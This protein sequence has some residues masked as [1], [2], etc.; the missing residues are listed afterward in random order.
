MPTG[1]PSSTATAHRAAEHSRRDP[2]DQP[3]AYRVSIAIALLV[4]LLVCDAR[5]QD[6]DESKT[7]DRTRVRELIGQLGSNTRAARRQAE[8]ALVSLGPAVLPFLPAPELL[9]TVSVK[10][11]VRR[12]RVTLEHQAAEQSVKASTVTLEGHMTLSELIPQLV[13]Q[14][15][16]TISLEKLT[17]RE[18]E[19][20]FSVNWKETPF[21][22]VIHEIE[23]SRLAFRFAAQS[24]AFELRSRSESDT[25]SQQTIQKAFRIRAGPVVA[26]PIAEDDPETVLN[27]PLR[28]ECEPRLRP[29]LL[30]MGTND[31]QLTTS[32]GTSI[33]PFNAGGRIELPLG[34]GGRE[35]RTDLTFLTKRAIDKPV[36]LVGKATVLTAALEQPVIFR[37]L[38]RA[39]G[40]SRR[41]GGVTVI[42][43]KLTTG[44]SRTDEPF[45]HIEISVSYDVGANAFES[46]QTWVFHNRV[47]LESDD[48]DRVSADGFETL[49]QGDGSVGVVYRFAN[50]DDLNGMK[51][52]Y[53]APTLLISVPLQIEIDDLEVS[54]ATARP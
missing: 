52:V 47:F 44:R 46:H 35:A 5:T 22:S 50:L 15:G 26:R 54:P 6:V 3:V 41:R 19:R 31:F 51:F 23:S 40:T 45:A 33:G 42:L 43:R 9:P 20:S 4:V 48:G 49:F 39:P 1:S 53:M 8:S 30:R 10:Q 24:G 11:A 14:T 17:A 12:I 36:K 38:E 2:R 21:W 32:D 34:D 28:I 13:K 37:D 29:L 7:A 18:L 25:A 27:C 16:N